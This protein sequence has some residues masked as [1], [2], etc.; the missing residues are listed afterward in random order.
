MQEEV[1]SRREGLF[2]ATAVNETKSK[3]LNNY[4]LVFTM[5]LYALDLFSWD[6]ANQKVSFV[7]TLLLV[8]GTT[9]CVA[10]Y[11]I[12]FLRKPGRRQMWKS[13]KERPKRFVGQMR[14][15]MGRSTDESDD[16]TDRKPPQLMYEKL[17]DWPE[18]AFSVTRGFQ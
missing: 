13:A 6:D 3:Q 5:A 12:S 10:G 14:R 16:E 7:V 4:F 15:R 2:T 1:K 11:A 17:D 18:H 8:P 9:Y